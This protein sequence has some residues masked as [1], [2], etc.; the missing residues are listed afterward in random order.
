MKPVLLLS[1]IMAFA[2][3]LDAYSQPDD[4]VEN[5]KL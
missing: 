5:Y 3:P 4:A 2:I 1:G